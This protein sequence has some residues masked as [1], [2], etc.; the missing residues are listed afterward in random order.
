[1]VFHELGTNAVKYGA[2]SVPEGAVTVVWHVDPGAQH[3]LTLHWRSAAARPCRRPP[4][5]VRPRA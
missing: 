5:R 1:M 2:L 3:R 4:A